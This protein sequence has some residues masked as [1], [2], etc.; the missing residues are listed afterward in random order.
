MTTKPQ[1]TNFIQGMAEHCTDWVLTTRAV[2][3]HEGF[4]VWEWAFEC[5]MVKASPLMPD[6]KAN[7]QTLKMIGAS[8]TWWDEEGKIVKNHDYGKWLD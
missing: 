5:K 2:E 4:S 1:L 3:A 8:L 6:I 7:G